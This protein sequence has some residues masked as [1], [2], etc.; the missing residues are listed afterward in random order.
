MVLSQD[1]QYRLQII[2]YIW[3][4]QGSWGCSAQF[5][6]TESDAQ[7]NIGNSQ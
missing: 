1:Y 6:Q 3:E 4:S 5:S 7:A 2:D